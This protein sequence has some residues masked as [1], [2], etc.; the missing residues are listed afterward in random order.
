MSAPIRNKSALEVTTQIAILPKRLLTLSM[1]GNSMQF[2]SLRHQLIGDGP[3]YVHCINKLLQA[4]A[5]NKIR[6]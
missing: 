3:R 6:A 1:S 4:C 2:S 5:K